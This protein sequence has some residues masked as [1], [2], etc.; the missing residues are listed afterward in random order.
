LKQNNIIALITILLSICAQGQVVNE[1]ILTGKIVV[2][3][4]PTA[5][6]HVLN[7]VNEKE[8]VSDSLGI[9][10]IMAKPD[11]LLVFT[12]PNLE[13]HRYSIDEDDMNLKHLDIKMFTKA[14]E[15]QV[16]YVNA[17]PGI[18]ARALGIIPK[19]Q[20]VVTPAERG[21]YSQ[22]NGPLQAIKIMITGKNPA[23]DNALKVERNIASLNRLNG[24]FQDNYYIETLKIN[25]DYIK[26]FQYYCI[27]DAEF[28]ASLKSKNKWKLM[29]R[30]V[31][32]AE[33]YN[34]M[35]ASQ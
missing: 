15:L 27:E 21:R 3:A 14:I 30:I 19:N 33:I 10:N 23:L 20:K 31:K 8:T 11:D 35:N 7:M 18:N 26:G 12:A 29:F 34:E 25:K 13:I 16:V 1:K 22:P 24:I 28:S 4:K 9:F 6:V 17:H 2:N 32:L 5:G